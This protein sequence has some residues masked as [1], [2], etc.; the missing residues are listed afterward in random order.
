MKNTPC[1]T[2]RRI[3]P[4]NPSY[5]AGKAG[6]RYGKCCKRAKER[7]RN[8]IDDDCEEWEIK[9]SVKEEKPAGLKAR[10]ENPLL[11]K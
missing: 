7:P 1:K 2:T 8:D 10:Y 11:R 5:K 6:I 4:E 3:K 9:L